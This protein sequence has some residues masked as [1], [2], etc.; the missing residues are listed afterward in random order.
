MSRALSAW[1][2]GAV[3]GTLRVNQHG[4]MTF[5]YSPEWL[6]DDAR[7]SLSV[8]LPKRPEVFKRRECRPF[9]AGL[10]PEASQRHAI[11]RAL[12]VSERN[13]FRLLESLGGDVAGALSLWPEGEAPPSRRGSSKTRPLD[14]EA[15]ASLLDTLP[16]RPMLA[17]QEG[18]RLSL[19][20]AQSKLPVVLI[21]GKVALPAAGQPTTHIV[22]PAMTQLPAMTENETLVMRLAAALELSV[23]PVE[24][25]TA[26]NRRYLLV[27]RYDRRFDVSGRAVRLHQE[28]LCQ[29]LGVPP[30]QKYADEGGPTLKTSFE[31]LRR[32]STRPALEVLRLLDATIF[33]V[34]VGNCDAHGKNFS[35]LHDNRG[36]TL[37]PLYDLVCTVAYPD[38]SPRFA[39]KIGKAATLEEIRRS[40]WTA[41]AADASVGE[42]F[43]RRRVAALVRQIQV[44][45]PSLV[46]ELTDAGLD[47]KAIEKYASLITARAVRLTKTI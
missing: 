43:I 5:S 31:L 41:L 30:E 6:A 34:I 26:T 33:N 22:K 17:G 44:V 29:A 15:L 18:L 47:F 12:G 21:K 8:S 2:D 37:A 7:A 19:A 35:L 16:Q 36:I 14:E 28:D 11:A 45:K 38:L 40:T 10:L 42:P 20:G 27:T 3:A 25:R 4:D 9:F 46:E 23:A 32:V 24:A 1:W 39:M 13:D